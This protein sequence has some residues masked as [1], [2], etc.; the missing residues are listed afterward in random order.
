MK[1]PFARPRCPHGKDPG[2]YCRKCP[3]WTATAS[4]TWIWG[5]YG[6]PTFPFTAVLAIVGIV[7]ALAVIAT[8]IVFVSHLS[9][10]KECARYERL[11]GMNT[12]YGF[13]G[14]CFVETEDGNW[15]TLATYKNQH[16]IK[17]R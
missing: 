16:N 9:A 14:G 6:I 11:D 15:V 10:S 5:E 3:R 7:T 17:I 4:P 13:F 8:P 12:D 2:A 1:N